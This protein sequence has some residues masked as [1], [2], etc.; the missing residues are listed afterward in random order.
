MHWNCYILGSKEMLITSP[1][2]KIKLFLFFE[3][4]W[5]ILTRTVAERELCLLNKS[6][7]AV[8][9][10]NNSYCFIAV[11]EHK[12]LGYVAYQYATC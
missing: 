12:Q 8:C 5:L 9:K 11:Q 10:G 3:M 7:K 6:L 1:S 2:F 4:I